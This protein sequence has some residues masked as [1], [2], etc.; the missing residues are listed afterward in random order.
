M[1]TII[2][3]NGINFAIVQQARYD[4]ERRRGTPR[5]RGGDRPPSRATARC[6]AGRR[7]RRRRRVRLADADRVPRVLAVRRDRRARDDRGVDRDDRRAAGAVGAVR[8][9]PGAP[10]V[11]APW[12]ARAGCWSGRPKRCSRPA[13][14]LARGHDRARCRGY[15]GDPFEYD[16][17]KLRN[18]ATPRRRWRS[19]GSRQ[20]FGETVSPPVMLADAPRRRCRRSPRSCA[21]APDARRQASD[22][23]D[24]HDRRPDPGR[25]DARS[26]RCSPSYAAADRFRTW[27]RRRT[28]DRARPR[29]AATARR[30]GPVTVADLPRDG[31]AICSPRSTA[32]SG[33]VVLVYDHPRITAYDGHA[34]LATRRPGRRGRRCP[35]ARS[36]AARSC[37]RRCIRGIVARRADRDRAVAARRDRC[38]SRSF[39]R[40]RRGVALVIGALVVGVSWMVG[41]A[42]WF[43]VKV[44]FLNFIALPISF[45]IGV[46][47]AHQHVP[48]LRLEGPARSA[49][50]C[51]AWAAR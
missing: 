30:A 18:R 13:R 32:R 37:S 17:T 24:P 48:A 29:G 7:A 10:A 2:V 9:R 19:R 11:H 21:R 35:T 43:G 28:D 49:A 4:E 1:G 25:S 41:A 46:D 45:G 40:T 27:R 3:G 8:R 39:E 38:S 36:R 47:Y 50:R 42:A 51:A 44:N 5:A 34:H 16:L 20:I 33:R 22:L 14:V 12:P 6:D 26:S 23:G 15:L 31:P